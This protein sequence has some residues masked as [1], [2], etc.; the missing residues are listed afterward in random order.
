[1]NRQTVE[2]G[3]RGGEKQTCHLKKTGYVSKHIAGLITM[4]I[5]Y[6]KLK[7]LILRPAKVGI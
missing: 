5:L 6:H 1:M 7:E 4:K 2:L 3:L